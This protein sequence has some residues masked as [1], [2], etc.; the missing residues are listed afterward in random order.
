MFWRLIAIFSGAITKSL[1]KTATLFLYGK[2]QDYIEPVQFTSVSVKPNSILLLVSSV[3]VFFC[4]A[5]LN[6]ILN[7]FSLPVFV[8]LSSILSRTSS[9][10]LFL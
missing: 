7:Q 3:H 10:Y 1:L 9:V 4:N 8:R 5:K 2:A 6:I